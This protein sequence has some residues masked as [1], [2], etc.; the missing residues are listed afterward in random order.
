LLKIL[1]KT[2]KY[3]SS[4][5]FTL[6]VICLLGVTFMVGLWVPQARLVKEIYL[7]WHRNSPRLVEFLDALGLT[8]IYTSPLT[9]TL[10]TLF[11]VNLAL[12][13]WQRLPVV[14]Q[15]IA[16][17]QANILDPEKAAGYPFRSSLPLPAG[18]DGATVL[19]RLR[20]RRYRVLEDDRGFYAVKN[21]LAPVAFLL[22]H[23]SFYLVLLGGL[24]SIYTEFLGYLDLAQGER[25]HGELSRYNASPA[26]KMPAFG[27]APPASFAV[28]SI[29]PSVVLNTPTSISVQLLDDD[30]HSHE[31]GINTPYTT[32]ATS[33]V[34]KHLG[35]APHF[36]LKNAAG[37]ELDNALVKLDV[38][39]MLPDKFDFG[40]YS[41]TATFYPDFVLE[42]GARAS[43]TREFNNP[44]F[45]IVAE[46]DG[47]KVGEGLVPKNGSLEFG[48]NRLEMRD[49]RYWVRF[50]V[51]TDRGLPVLYLGFAVACLAV[52]WR[53][54]F[55]KREL[56]GA[57]REL[58]GVRTLL[59]AG[60]SEFYKDLAEDEFNKLLDKITVAD[61]GS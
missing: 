47:K 48:G 14:R 32:G 31:V 20:R 2:L 30:R 4:V 51:V 59:I 52:L 6:V 13:L 55:Y 37:Q 25:F 23:V 54:I 49:L 45:F 61:S 42:K 29:T 34:F 21:R 5:R 60:R 19:A 8:T 17:S 35:M 43:R 24:I 38:L 33:F 11:F 27:S 44:T 16:L 58:D 41:F 1:K 3:L 15:R 36:V 12:V 7:Q 50:Y 53:M 26:V 10:W 28:T 9:I 57:V 39:R 18:L 40:G 22:F 56:V 46:R